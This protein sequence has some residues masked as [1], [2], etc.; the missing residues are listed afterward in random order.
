LSLKYIFKDQFENK[1][2]IILLINYSIINRNNFLHIQQIILNVVILSRT[3][4]VESH[5]LK[6]HI[7]ICVYKKIILTFIHQ[8]K[9]KFLSKS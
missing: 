1:L 3:K 2:E 8:L 4:L 9:F 7:N 6:N 5:T